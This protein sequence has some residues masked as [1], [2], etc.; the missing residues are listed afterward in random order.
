MSESQRELAI[1]CLAAADARGAHPGGDWLEDADLDLW[2]HYFRLARAAWENAA[3]ER[4]AR[5]ADVWP[6]RSVV[7]SRIERIAS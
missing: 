3:V 7:M 5:P 6:T 2:R 4:T 1:L